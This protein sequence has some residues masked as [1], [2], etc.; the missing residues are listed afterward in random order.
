MEGADPYQ[1]MEGE[2]AA[3]ERWLLDHHERTEASLAGT[4]REAF[5]ARLSALIAGTSLLGDIA[6]IG[7]TLFYVRDANARRTL[8]AHRAGRDELVLDVARLD[9]D[10]MLLAWRISP[11]GRYVAANLAPPGAEI[12]EIWIVELATGTVLPDRI[13]G[14]HNELPVAWH[15]DSV[16]YTAID[17]TSSDPV[18]GMRA[19]R[20]RLGDSTDELVI[21]HRT[22]GLARNEIPWISTAPESAW[23]LASITSA[24]AEQRV[25]AAPSA[26]VAGTATPW[27]EL[28]GY[29]DLVEDIQLCGDRAYALVAREQIDVIDLTS[30][31]RQLLARSDRV[32]DGF[33][34]ARDGVYFRTQHE[35]TS[36]VRWSSHD[37]RRTAIYTLPTCSW[38]SRFASDV[39]EDGAIAAV[40]AW[41]QP[42]RLVA[43][44]AMTELGIVATLAP[45]YEGILAEQVEISSDDGTAVP[46]TILRTRDLACDGSHPAILEAYGGFGI[47]L[48]PGCDPLRIAW[49]ERGGVY[50][51]AHV[52]GGGEKGRTWHLAGKGANKPNA[53]RD[54]LACA[55]ALCER[56][57]TR[58]ERLA[59]TA[60]SM[61]AVV[62]GNALAHA[63]AQFGAA[64][65][66]AGL[67]NASRYLHSI[68]GETQR[69]E[70]GDDL[71]A[72]AAMDVYGAAATACLPPLLLSVG[73]N[74][75]RV[76]PWMSAKLAA[77]LLDRDAAVAVRTDRAGHGMTASPRQIAARLA[78]IWTFFTQQLG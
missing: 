67:V 73:L 10:A 4:A 68:N 65:L 24:R 26:S 35:R 6:Y 20:H 23:L 1:W 7:N 55:R 27:R 28:A 30:S 47:S 29:D 78:D 39:R 34:V 57:Y 48:T 50:A 52:R 51:I 76:S 13:A 64:A 46:L 74:D 25:Y 71:D 37:A 38:I 59:A 32:I 9:R 63:P 49:L 41:T 69:E 42:T 22:L 14:V 21:D 43:Y 58:P 45:E 60:V 33:T 56:G 54:Y 5:R 40:D 36:V 19:W 72:L 16:F 70:L 3:V 15:G 77:R 75:E 18:L 8:W 61:G 31:Q 12:G 44:P 62:V 2:P 17:P 53:I 11:D 66:H